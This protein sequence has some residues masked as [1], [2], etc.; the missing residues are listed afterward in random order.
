[1]LVHQFNK[2]LN[3]DIDVGMYGST[4]NRLALHGSSDL[5]IS[6]RI[7]TPHEVNF[8]YL[9]KGVAK[10]IRYPKED[11]YRSKFVDFTV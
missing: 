2:R 1:M 7:I 8:S 9:Y 10:D 11:S 5:D 6:V 4:F 3:F